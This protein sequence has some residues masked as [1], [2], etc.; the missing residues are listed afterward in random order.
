[1]AL[2]GCW[3]HFLGTLS[4]S[5]ATPPL[6]RALKLS[7]DSAQ[8]QMDCSNAENLILHWGFVVQG[9]DGWQL[10]ESLPPRSKNYKDRAV[11]T[12]LSGGRMS[13]PLPPGALAIEFLF[14]DAKTEKWYNGPQSKNFRFDVAAPTSPPPSPSPPPPAVPSDLSEVAAFVRWEK[15]GKPSLSEEQQAAMY[16]AAVTELQLELER[17][18]ATLG[19]QRAAAC[20]AGVRAALTAVFRPL[21]RS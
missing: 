3:V 8:L 13:V 14:M 17:G 9:K 15:A 19:A 2:F 7:V 11:K 21:F 10:P 4:L 18:V 20:P 6:P 1:M 16:T 5:S 12:E